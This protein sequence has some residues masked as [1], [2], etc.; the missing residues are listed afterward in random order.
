[1][2]NRAKSTPK[3]GRPKDQSSQDLRRLRRNQIILAVISLMMIVSLVI[4]LIKF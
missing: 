2:A 3:T 4:S 1:M